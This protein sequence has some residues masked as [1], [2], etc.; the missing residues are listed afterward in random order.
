M[1]IRFYCSGCGRKLNVKAFQAGRRGLCPYCGGGIQIPTESTR[2]SSRSLRNQSDPSRNPGVAQA[3][4]PQDWPEAPR[5]T[6]TPPQ[7]TP[8][9]ASEQAALALPAAPAEPGDEP[10]AFP[11]PVDYP[12]RIDPVAMAI[13]DAADLSQ[14]ASAG[15]PPGPPAEG[16]EV[17]WYVRPPEGG[18]YGPVRTQV[19]QAWIAEGRVRADALVWREGWRDWQEAVLAFSELGGG[20]AGPEP[21]AITA[22]GTTSPAVAADGHRRSSRRRST[23]ESAAVI[24]V[25]VLAVIVLFGVFLWVLE[26]GF[27]P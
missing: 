11:S 24:T 2:P 7:N 16:T 14:A 15:P 21:G 6:G 23:A 18:Q 20:E 1:G 4:T 19:I 8:D 17:V 13:A 27:S 3:T 12:G 9:I 26:G 10:A 22:T 25:L 5:P